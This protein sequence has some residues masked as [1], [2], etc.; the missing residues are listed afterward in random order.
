MNGRMGRDDWTQTSGSFLV[1]NQT[2]GEDATVFDITS[3]A[4]VYGGSQRH[5]SVLL[6]FQHPISP[7]QAS[8]TS[9]LKRLENPPLSTISAA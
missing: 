6:R 2:G 3:T 4:P 1:F 8:M 9:T 5:Y 7:G